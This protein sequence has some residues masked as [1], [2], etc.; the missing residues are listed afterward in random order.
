MKKQKR[1]K[2]W[3]DCNVPIIIVEADLEKSNYQVWKEFLDA[4]TKEISRNQD[5]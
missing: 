3:T 4:K 5:T 1:I 2:Q